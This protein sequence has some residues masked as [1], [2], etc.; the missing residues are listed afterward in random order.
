MPQGC[1]V[2]WFQP[3]RGEIVCA[4]KEDLLKLHT[5]LNE[6]DNLDDESL[7]ILTGNQKTF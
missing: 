4:G 5:T 6:L 2:D 1:E 7:R 3:P